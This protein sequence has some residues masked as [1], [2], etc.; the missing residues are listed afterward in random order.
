MQHTPTHWSAWTP[1]VPAHLNRRG[2]RFIE[3][4]QGG[5]PAPAAPAAPADPAPAA[6]PTPADVA[7]AAAAGAKAADG[8]EA[9]TVEELPD[10]AQNIVRDA[11][12]EAAKSRVNGKT[13]AEEAQKAITEQIGKAL[14]LVKDGD[15]APDPAAL[16]QAATEAQAEAK[17]ARVELAV[18]RAA[19]AAQADPAAL[20]D[21]RAF[22]DAVKDVDPTDSAA[23]TAAIK[24]ALTDNPRLKAT[25][26]VPNKSGG[27]LTGG[28]GE[29][30]SKTPKTLDDAVASRYGNA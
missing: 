7:A 12:A 19:G 9:K 17:A 30:Q 15:D 28:T 2:L 21:S 4:G 29:G 3:G 8:T 20:L 5:D 1:G 10:W 25:P 27:D 23:I 6:T 11:R 26:A 18:Y 16:T 14:G 24:S 22:L 13:A